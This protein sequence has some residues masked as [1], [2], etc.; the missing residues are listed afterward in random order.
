MKIPR[1]V[2]AEEPEYVPNLHEHSSDE[3]DYDIP[4]GKDEEIKSLKGIYMYF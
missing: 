4:D 2:S 1:I 3:E